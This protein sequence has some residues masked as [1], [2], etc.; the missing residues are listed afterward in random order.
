MRW[1]RVYSESDWDTHHYNDTWT[2]SK[3]NVVNFSPIH[4]NKILFKYDFYCCY[5][6]H[7]S[8]QCYHFIIIDNIIDMNCMNDEVCR[9]FEAY[10]RHVDQWYVSVE[11]T[12]KHDEITQDRFVCLIRGITCV[13]G[14]CHVRWH[15][16][17]EDDWQIASF[18]IRGPI[19]FQGMSSRLPLDFLRI[20]VHYYIQSFSSLS[21]VFFSSSNCEFPFHHHTGWVYNCHLLKWWS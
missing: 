10:P 2:R 9:L 17:I 18:L 14:R 19:S 16:A 7:D 15:D 20:P 12:H 1:C 6:K 13:S 11:C 4:E 21:H 3:A 5:C 8:D